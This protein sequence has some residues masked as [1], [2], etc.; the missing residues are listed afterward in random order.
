MKKH[1]LLFSLLA[2]GSAIANNEEKPFSMDGEFGFIATSGNTETTSIKG[3]LAAHQELEQWSNDYKAEALYK[4]DQVNGESTTTAQKYFLSGQA[5][6]KLTNPDHRIFGFVSHEDDRFSAFDYQSTI[7]AG[8]SQKVWEN[9][10]SRFK[11]S[12]GPGYSFA[13]RQDGTSENSAIVRASLDYQ[14]KISDTAQFKQLV[15]TEV[16][17]DNTKSKS[18]SSISAKISD[19]FSLKV[20]L[21]LDHNSDVPEGIENLDTQT[22]VTVVYTFF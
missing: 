11:Y 21:V 14:W 12:V 13:Q 18:E 10:D 8:W 1:L 2:T 19:S 6:Y 7:A 5:N 4:K 17:G 22:A 20:S 15:S 9:D 16:G 3:K